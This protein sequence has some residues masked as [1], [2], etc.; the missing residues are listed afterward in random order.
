[1]VD[2]KISP[3]EVQNQGITFPDWIGIL[4]LCFA[5]LIAHVLS[6]APRPSYLSP[7]RPTWHDQLTHYNPTS[8]LW[9]YAAITDRRIRAC[10]VI[11]QSYL[12]P[13]SPLTNVDIS[14]DDCSGI[15]TRRPQ[16]TP[17][18]GQRLVGMALRGWPFS[19]APSPSDSQSIP[20]SPFF[21]PTCFGLS[22]SRR[23][24]PR[25]CTP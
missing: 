16:A 1:M 15:L 5:P 3:L 17:C 8:I 12:S 13:P 18:F 24:E 20:V 9:R 4:T 23:R 22:L 11:F 21:L 25:P 10:I 19:H 7:T 6:G 2:Y 14:S